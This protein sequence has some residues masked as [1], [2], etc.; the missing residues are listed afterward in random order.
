[1]PTI[2]G[3]SGFYHDSAAAL[4]RDGDVIAAI[5]EERITR[6]KADPEFP[7]GAI[8]LCLSMAGLSLNELDAVAF[9]EL[10]SLKFDRLIETFLAGAPLSF[11]PFAAAMPSWLSTKLRVR[12]Q[13]R[14]RFDNQLC[15]PIHFCPH[16]LSHA[17][18]AFYPSPFESAAIL[19]VDGVGEWATASISHGQSNQLTPLVEQRFPHSLGLLYSAVTAY[20]GFEINSGEYKLMGL[21]ASGTPRFADSMRRDIVYVGDDGAIELDQRFFDYC[22]GLK[23]TSSRFHRYFG[24]PP[25]AA[26]QPLSELDCDLA[27]SVQAIT[28][29]ALARMAS[30]ACRL[31]GERTLCLAGGVAL[32]CVAV[33]K[34]ITES[35]V[36]K[37]W[38]QP[39]AGDAGGAVGAALW[40]SHQ[41]QNRP[42]YGSPKDSYHG[43]FLG[44]A[45]T[46]DQVESAIKHAG[47]NYSK[48]SPDTLCHEVASLIA[49][50]KIVGWFQDKM[51]FGPRALGHRSILA[52]PRDASMKDKINRLVKHREPFRPFAPAVLVDS[53]PRYF[54]VPPRHADQ[55]YMTWTTRVTQPD[56]IPAVTHLDQSAR[57]QTVDA[58]RNP[59]FFQ[60]IQSFDRLTGIPIL[61]NT[62]FNDR[63][64]PIVCTPEDAL[65]CFQQT[66]LDALAIEDFLIHKQAIPQVDPI[67]LHS[68][69]NP[70]ESWFDKAFRIQHKLSYPIRWL[71]SISSLIMVYL[72]VLTPIGILRRILGHR[73]LHQTGWHPFTFPSGSQ[74][75][76]SE[77]NHGS[78][79]SELLRFLIE[80]KKWWL[81]PI[82]ASLAVVAV[83]ASVGGSVAPWIYALW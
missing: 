22:H 35:I 42:R 69:N 9:Y 71:G 55:P 73:P 59:K 43:A 13:I 27:A 20:C 82:A 11:R 32:N 38:V 46:S 81:I 1:M 76:E 30:Y 57:I 66:G 56:A 44:P 61:L 5:Q 63:D 19:T 75:N 23:M 29:S 68:P 49:N 37:V 17:A 74:S 67:D 10:P 21:A 16:H 8:D 72:L 28:E 80:E 62:S 40:L 12:N 83:A 60:L 65:R 4:V 77:D 36:D 54:Q 79:W 2:L 45:Y 26:N 39:A 24:R 31:T 25:R 78:W 41:K 70:T 53:A 51:E 47:L 33:G 15:P 34:L 58:A 48:P 6:R 50:G 14:K 64:E 3:L 52:D 18:S 7:Q